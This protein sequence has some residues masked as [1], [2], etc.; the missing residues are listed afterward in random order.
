MT[1]LNWKENMISY[2]TLKIRIY[3]YQKIPVK[4][5]QAKSKKYFWHMQMSS[6]EIIYEELL[7][8]NYPKE[9]HLRD[10]CR[11]FMTDNFQ[12]EIFMT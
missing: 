5:S 10:L 6:K 12:V 1:E 7:Q 9:K 8:T 3:I 2:T 4:K 11:L